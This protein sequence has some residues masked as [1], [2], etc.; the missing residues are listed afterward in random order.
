M[1]ANRL[2]KILPAIITEHQSAFTKDRLISD[3]ILI[4]FETLHCMKKHNIGN[5]DF[6]ALKLDMSKAYDR[7]EWSFL[8]ALMRKIG[9]N[10][11]WIGLI[12]VCVKMVTYSILTNGEPR[13]MILPTRG[14]RQG[15]PLLPFLFLLCKEGLHWIINQA[16]RWGE[17]TSFSICKRGPKLTY[18][19]FANDSLLFYKATLDEC[20]K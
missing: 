18:L 20:E 11:K 7:V 17:I 4:P 14:I 15:D 10:E 3:N 19:L 13:G 16:V 6:M 8:E 5:F 2:K 12:M 1:L 9:F